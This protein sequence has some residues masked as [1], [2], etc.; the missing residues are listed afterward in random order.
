MMNLFKRFLDK[1][2][3]FF[4]ILNQE[5]PSNLFRQKEKINSKQLKVDKKNK[6]MQKTKKQESK[7][8]KKTRKNPKKIKTKKIKT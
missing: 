8:K 5:S 3:N 2:T 1:K 6:E 4:V 7:S